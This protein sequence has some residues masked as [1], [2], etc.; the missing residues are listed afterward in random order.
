MDVIIAMLNST[1]VGVTNFFVGLVFLPLRSFL[2]DGDPTKEGHVFYVFVGILLAA[3]FS[4][5]RVYR[6]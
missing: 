4:L 6:G 1:F 3:T 5:S 2:S